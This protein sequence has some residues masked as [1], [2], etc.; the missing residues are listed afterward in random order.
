MIFLSYWFFIFAI[1]FFAIFWALPWGLARRAALAVGC[2][3]FQIH[4]AG[5]AG[6]APIVVIAVVT[7]LCGLAA[8]PVAPLVGIATCAAALMVYK[9]SVFVAANT[10][11]AI[12]ENWGSSAVDVLHGLLPATPPLA[13]SFF[14]FEF[15]HYLV[16]V[17]RGGRPIRNP[18]DFALFGTFWPSL[19]AGPIKRYQQFLPALAQGTAAVD[20]L[21]VVTG[22]LRVSVGITKK[23][24][25]DYLGQITGFWD[26]K[27]E[28]LPQSQRI[29]IVVAI[30]FRILFDFSGYSDMAI[31]FARMMGIR[32][33]ENFRWPYLATNLVSFWR[34]WHISLSTWI[35][36]YI[37]FALG[38]SRYG[39][40][41]RLLNG[42]IAFALCGLWHGAAWHF[43]LWG[44]YHGA[45]LVV[46]VIA[47]HVLTPL[48]DRVPVAARYAACGVGWLMTTTFVMLGWLLF[49][50]PVPQ[51]LHMLRL[52]VFG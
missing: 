14:V 42:A 31:G 33:P 18:L 11:G 21:D 16:D 35:R 13:I 27:L 39:M 5:A 44:L 12:S 49:F 19:V 3:A 37:Y 25:G 26:D 30:G 52:C 47:L 38:G 23:F 36:D 9:Y 48:R 24:A 32:L 6:V 4:F 34:R 29:L 22:M 20:R 51:A 40:A 28:I 17:R 8:G 10:A 45:G 7:Y 46:S 43:V 15:V 50:Y 41:R 1:V 2:V